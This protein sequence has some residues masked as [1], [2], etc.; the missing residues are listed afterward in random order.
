MSIRTWIGMSLVALACTGCGGGGGGGGTTGNNPPP[1]V[2]T[3]PPVVDPT[4]PTF[5]F[6]AHYSEAQAGDLATLVL[7]HGSHLVDLAQFAT[8]ITHRFATTAGTTS[9]TAN[10]AYTGSITLKLDDRD[11]N[12]RAS[13]GDSITA[14][15][16]NCGVPVLGRSATGTLRIDL[17]TV[18]TTADAGFQARLAV[19][20]ALKTTALG[21]GPNMGI[22]L[23]ITWRG[24]V[25]IQWTESATGS[26]LKA[27]STAED[28][29]RL[30]TTIQGGDTTDALR[31]IE[32]SRSVGYDTASMSSAL[33]YVL[34]VGGSGNTLRVRTPQPIRGDLSVLPRQLRVE[35][36]MAASQTL[37]I[38]RGP[39]NA[40]VPQAS[41][42]LVASN[43]TAGQ[44]R[45][46]PWGDFLSLMKDVR[47]AR[48]V[49]ALSD[50]GFGFETFAS[51]RGS[52]LT[53]DIDRICEQQTT[54]GISRFRADALFQR[55]VALQP[56][57][58]EPGGLMRLQFGRAIADSTPELR[59]RLAD[60]A[61][62]TDSKLP[63][64]HVPVTA[65][66]HG[67]SYEIRPSEP[68]RKERSYS[69]QTSF[70]GINWTGERIFRDAQNGIVSQ[71][72]ESVALLR[73]DNVL[74]AAATFSD[75][76]TVAA[77]APARLRGEATPR[78]GQAVTRYQWEQLSGAPLRLST[79]QAA[80][81]EAILDASGALPI[82][83]ALLQL[84]VTDSLG[85]TDRVR[86]A[87]KAGN[88]AAQGAA[89]YTE[90]LTGRVLR[91][92]L[93]TGTGS[94]FYG[95]A[96]GQVLPRVPGL[97]EGGTG[98][99][100]SVTPANGQ[101]L[102]VGTYANAIKDTAPGALNGLVSQ[103]FCN[104]EGSPVSGSFQ[105]LDVDY[106]AD[107]SINRLAIDFSQQC[108][109]GLREYQRGSYRLNSSI[110]L[111]P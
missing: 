15:L 57:L 85:N 16:T 43:G 60:E 111:N 5:R 66:R 20:D 98:A 87:L 21:G 93:K 25:G 37:R 95:P 107:G 88:R 69:L 41:A 65:T 29:L 23:P 80:E 79:P 33:A 103:V 7:N 76:A 105:V 34:D 70:D 3:P 97:S 12:Q 75:Q 10:C 54:P 62:T 52:A 53:A 109:A 90:T 50:E 39:A 22:I 67:S 63:S 104:A 92:E 36:D 77:G 49:Y 68:L 13:A 27:V 42:V 73:T 101:R 72:S 28:D 2:E 31:K 38:E 106:A 64:W 44:S 83:D 81:T 55:P 91:R 58:S 51:W 26:Q 24:S 100:F 108:E 59:F 4:A 96:P 102:A 19:V 17:T 71:G 45:L 30:T 40:G 78:D 32:V 48:A 47:S 9:V 11:G 61:V 1:P 35:V 18:A 8:D 89:L 84:T 56:G 94:I 86:V 110:V 74:V 14:T 46:F 99:N 6:D 82:G